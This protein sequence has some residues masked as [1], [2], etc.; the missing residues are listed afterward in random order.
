MIGA[1]GK[2]S[3]VRDML[4]V[5][6]DDTAENDFLDDTHT[7]DRPAALPMKMFTGLS[8]SSSDLR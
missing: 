2:N 8:L 1:D 6:E 5:E 7:A 3:I 4:L